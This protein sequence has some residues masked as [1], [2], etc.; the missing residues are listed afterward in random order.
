[1]LR[2]T[3]EILPFGDESKKKTLRSVSIIND[4]THENHPDYGN[5]RVEHTD[6]NGESFTFEIHNHVRS[7]G[8]DCLLFKVFGKTDFLRLKRGKEGK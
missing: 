6:G 8:L 5:Y 3:V 4:G 1:M 7:D 2:V